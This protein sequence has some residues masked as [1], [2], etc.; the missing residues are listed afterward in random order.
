M[1]GTK[2]ILVLV[3]LML[4]ASVG[5]G[6]AAASSD[7]PRDQVY[8]TT[9]RDSPVRH[10]TDEAKADLVLWISN[11]SFEDWDV[12]LTVLIDGVPIA[13]GKFQVQDQ[14]T[15]ISLPLNLEP[16]DHELSAASTTGVR[17]VE[18]FTT[19]ATHEQRYAVLSYWFSSGDSI[20]RS[21]QWMWS[22]EPVHFD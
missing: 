16:G 15:W 3:A 12:G 7:D 2:S 18:T 13:D 6:C 21:L 14:H 5:G 20:D 19:P 8:V 17:T 1:R 4:L 11:Q 10:T 9:P 22:E